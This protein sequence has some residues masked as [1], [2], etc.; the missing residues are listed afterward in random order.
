MQSSELDTITAEPEIASGIK[1][2]RDLVSMDDYLKNFGGLLGKKAIHALRP[3]HIPNVT[4]LP[5]YSDLTEFNPDREL[6]PAQKDVV[7]AAI[8]M[9]DNVGSGFI[10]G[11]MGTGKTI[12]GM[13][14]AHKHAQRPRRQGGSGGKYRG[15]VLCPDH[16]IG[17]W[18]REIETT[19][20]GAKV[21]RFG[22]QGGE[23]K[24]KGKRGGKKKGEP[25]EDGNSKKTLA[26]T[27][28]LFEKKGQKPEGAEWY[29][30]GRNQAKW[31]SDW[32]GISDE[33]RGYDGGLQSGMSKKSI[34]VEKIDRLDERGYR[35][36]NDRGQKIVDNVTAKVYTCAKCGTVCRNKKGEILGASH[37]S[38]KVKSS[39]QEVCQGRWLQEIEDKDKPRKNDQHGWD[40]ICPVPEEYA[41]KKP[42]DKKTGRPADVF[43]HKG[44]KYTIVSCE[45]PLY[46]YTSRPYRWSPA[47]I[48]QKKLRNFFDYLII[49]EVHEH[50]SDSSGQS[51][52]CGKLIAS[53]KHVIALTGTIIGGY[54]DHLFPL[55]MRLS[56]KTL[57]AEGFEWESHMAFSEAYGRI[58]RIVTTK[59]DD[60]GGFAVGGNVK[61]MRR[62]K[63]GA[64][65]ERKAVRPGVMPTMFGKHMIGSSMF[66]TLNQIASELP[67]LFEYIG[68][69]LADAPKLDE[70]S[71][72]KDSSAQEK[73]DAEAE[74]HGRALAGWVDVACDME[75]DQAAEYRRVA[76]IMEFTNKELLKKGSMKMLG[77]YLWTTM[78][79]PDRPFGWGHDPELL[80][81]LAR[82]DTEGPQAPGLLGQSFLK[83]FDHR[84]DPATETLV[85]TRSNSGNTETDRIPLRK[86]GGVY[87]LD[88]TFNGKATK[89]LVYD[90]GASTISLSDVMAAEIG[91]TPK[92]DDYEASA[93]IAD[94][95][96]VKDKRTII[97]FVKVGKF[98][99]KD[100]E[101]SIQE[102]KRPHTVGY[103]DKPGIRTVEN[104]VGVVTPKDCPKDRIYP[105]EQKLIDICLMQKAEGTQTWVYVNMTS[106]RDIRDRLKGLLEATGLKVGILN[107]EDVPPIEREEWIKAN[108]RNY[109]VMI[110]HP[111][112]VSTGLDLFDKAPG[113]HNY[114][115]IVF[116]E[117]GYNLFTMRQAARRAW[118]IGQPRDC[119]LYYL[120]Y[121]E[122]MQHRA[123]QLMSR[124][125]S[126]A[127]AL[128]GEFSEDGLAA[129]SGEDNLQMAL[130]KSISERIDDKD[131]Q[132]SW[133][134]VNSGGSKLKKPTDAIK[135]LV[136]P[137]APSPL[138][139]LPIATQL[140]VEALIES[141]SKPI[142]EEA[143]GEFADVMSKLADSFTA[144]AASQPK[145]EPE[146]DVF[147]EDEDDLDLS[148]AA[149]A[150]MFAKLIAQGQMAA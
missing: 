150:A 120:Y 40:R 117:T 57:K 1:H 126:A 127:Q 106:K 67:D 132:R 78:D 20:P 2:I 137:A 21:T 128:E 58:D 41:S 99:V 100:V 53:A 142:P 87:W 12:L 98:T 133:G 6:F 55:M 61:S 71:D 147:S 8:K 47:R 31:L 5:D 73:F 107:A 96:I 108:G 38:C 26:D 11:E 66:I 92:K 134:K 103:W 62:A 124:K 111:Q 104:F 56:P 43:T 28:K 119:R 23:P 89:S 74:R 68:G 105:K 19:I 110:S 79:Y 125:M 115:T 77:A 131:L 118:R 140:V 109:D 63:S 4:P 84:F 139:N 85:L 101:C 90:T 83:R 51:M 54:A 136:E 121:T 22:P 114:S 9:L 70:F 141:E 42:A 59:E 149:M 33:R 16:L 34:I 146:Y 49:D 88:V 60:D 144:S 7:A 45:E 27:I 112:L 3:L 64:S 138:D 76:A 29:V 122:T 17:K 14:S 81:A 15:L 46:Y 35:Q 80:K 135:L 39:K 102:T 50:K 48:I 123:M 116:Y 36:Y 52:A 93:Q 18:V 97:D 143:K 94:G 95:S 86:E 65:N 148:D 130:A 44:R 129:M 91:L 30:M 75:P 37:L 69:T 82:S 145:V 25:K 32:M 24:E 13:C 10:V 72:D 113:G